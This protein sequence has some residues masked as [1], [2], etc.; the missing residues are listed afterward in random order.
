MIG[1]LEGSFTLLDLSEEMLDIARARFENAPN[2]SYV[3]QT[4]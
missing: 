2:F 1:T 3:A 4:I